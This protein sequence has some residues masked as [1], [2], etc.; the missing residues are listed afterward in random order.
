MTCRLGPV[1]A[2]ALL[3]LPPPTLLL[4]CCSVYPVI[5]AANLEIFFPQLKEGWTRV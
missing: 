3:T 4:P 5:L 2:Y 1:A